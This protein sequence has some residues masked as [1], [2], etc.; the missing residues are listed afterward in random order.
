MKDGDRFYR[1]VVLATVMREV[2]TRVKNGKEYVRRER[3][4][5]VKCD[6]GK[7]F[8]VKVCNV[9][10]G[11]TRSCGCTPRPKDEKRP[12][13]SENHGMSSH[14]LYRVWSYMRQ[15]CQNPN[16]TSYHSYGGR[17]I[18][19]CQEWEENPL[20]F[21][22]WGLANGYEPDLT[23]ERINNDGD[24]CPENCRFATKL[25]QN[26][27]TQKA[28]RVEA[29]GETKSYRAWS[30]DVRCVV[31]WYTLRERILKGVDA[32][33]AICTPPGEL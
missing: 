26:Q 32:E 23:L 20:E 7:R 2:G 31:P 24:Y 15:R 17:G 33:K 12:P 21:I 1:L 14:P 3:F 5:I 29:F 30:R 10:T 19:V 28:A 6:C 8:E 9:R 18:K 13:K 27:N 22:K 16:N 11:N 4:A 25:E